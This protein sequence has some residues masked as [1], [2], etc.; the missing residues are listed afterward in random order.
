MANCLSGND[1]EFGK[2]A[3]L[4]APLATPPFYAIE[5]IPLILNTAG[6]PIIDKNAR[7]LSP[8]ETPIPGL[9]AA[10]NN[11]AGFYDSYP[12]TGTG[13]QISSIFDQV[14]AEQIK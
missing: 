8:D 7:V 6:G 12:C 11:T 14:A 3:A 10:G 5:I 13:L 9:Y 2:S 1:E 4:L